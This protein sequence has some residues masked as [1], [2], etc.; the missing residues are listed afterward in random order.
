MSCVCNPWWHALAFLLGVAH[1]ANEGTIQFFSDPSCLT[2]AGEPITAAWNACEA[3]DASR[4]Y[5]AKAVLFPACDSG[6]AVLEISDMKL[7]SP[8]S[9]YPRAL[10]SVVGECLV[11]PLGTGIASAGFECQVPVDSSSPSQVPPTKPTT[12]TT[13]EPSPSPKSTES[14]PGGFDE[15]DKIALGVGIGIGLP[16]LLVAI[17]VCC[18]GDPFRRIEYEWLLPIH[19]NNLQPPP[20]RNGPR[21]EED[22]DEPP[23]PYAII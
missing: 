11:I 16:T 13:T 8:P 21:P 3:S 10:T 12:P 2:V 17:W 1:A 5:G 9:F 18:F 15:S 7:C 14:P 4:N 23:P 22:N 20:Y 19:R 6:K